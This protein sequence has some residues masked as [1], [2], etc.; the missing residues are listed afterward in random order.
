MKEKLELQNIGASWAVGLAIIWIS[1]CYVSAQEGGENERSPEIDRVAL[2]EQIE[3]LGSEKFLERE[4]ALK[5]LMKL[6]LSEL[7]WLEEQLKRFGAPTEIETRSRLAKV[8]AKMRKQVSEDLFAEVFKDG[9]VTAPFDCVVFIEPVGGVAGAA[10]EIGLGSTPQNFRPFITGLPRKAKPKS[11]EL[12][13]F[14]KGESVPLAISSEW[15]GVHYA[16]S[17]KK[18]EASLCAF[19]DT[20]GSL[21]VAG[22]RVFEPTEKENRFL[23]RLDDAASI[24]VDDND[25]DILIE[26]WFEPVKEDGEP[27]EK[28]PA[29]APLGES[30]QEVRI[31]APN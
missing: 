15:G 17:G 19:T 25:Q 1:C 18:D 3:K 14:A 4:D 23:M 11:A 13:K 26:I 31:R 30:D 12:G 6:P 7:P 5:Q 2:S 10:S 29:G 24:K 21:Q 28:A 20:D 8:V 27:N 16:F 9:V 22:S